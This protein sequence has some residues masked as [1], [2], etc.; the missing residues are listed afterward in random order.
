MLCRNFELIPIKIRFFMNFEVAPKFD[1]TPCTIVHG[2]RPD[3]IKNDLERILHF[4]NF[5]DTYTCSHVV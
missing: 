4:Y 3:F 5:F 2:L 1:K